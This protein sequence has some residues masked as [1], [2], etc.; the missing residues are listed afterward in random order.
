M[1]YNKENEF[2]YRGIESCPFQSRQTQTVLVNSGV[3]GLLLNRIIDILAIT[4]SIGFDFEHKVIS[5]DPT[6]KAIVKQRT[7]IV[8]KHLVAIGSIPFLIIRKQPQRMGD[9]FVSQCHGIWLHCVLQQEK[10]TV[11]VTSGASG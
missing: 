3:V 2:N 10:Q 4:A 5:I 11:L 7:A 8:I 6:Q 9:R 1:F